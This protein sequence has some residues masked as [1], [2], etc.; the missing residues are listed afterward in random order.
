MDKRVIKTQRNITETFLDLFYKN[1]FE[2]ITVKKI[3]EAAEI[4]RK[5]FYLHYLDKY[6]LLDAIVQTH[7]E[8]LD[9]ICEAKKDL[10]LEE[11]TIIWFN[12]FEDH[13]IFF[14]R[15]FNIK[16]ADE[17]KQKLQKFIIRQLDGKLSTTFMKAHYLSEQLFPEFFAAGIVQMV[18]IYIQDE[19]SNKAAIENQVA[20]LLQM[21]DT[22]K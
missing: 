7:F 8:H 20:Q 13:Q 5:T 15:L 1:D 19:D 11:G 3:A 4:E 6:D 18:M 14:K 17:Y 21:V 2:K 10:G 16:N 22:S 9:E 12:F